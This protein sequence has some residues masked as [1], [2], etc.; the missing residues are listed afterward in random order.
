[1]DVNVA[2]H[3]ITEFDIEFWTVKIFLHLGYATAQISSV[4]KHK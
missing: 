2:F 4:N 1:M 3:E